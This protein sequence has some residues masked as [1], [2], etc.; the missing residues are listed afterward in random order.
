MYQH[1]LTRK[2]S[3]LIRTMSPDNDHS[4]L[5]IAAATRLTPS[6]VSVLIDGLTR[7]GVLKPAQPGS[8]RIKLT[9]S[10]SELRQQLLQGGVGFS[11]STS[12]VMIT[13]DASA[14][15][16][17]KNLESEKPDADLESYIQGLR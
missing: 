5:D 7:R 10:G 4:P 11:P 6:E 1:I 17:R 15:R 3:D 13:D 8:P 16:M 14:E 2:E 9:P 12:S